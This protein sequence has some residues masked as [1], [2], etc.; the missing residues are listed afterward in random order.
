MQKKPDTLRIP[1][2]MIYN[3]ETGATNFKYRDVSKGD[4]EETIHRLF[5]PYFSKGSANA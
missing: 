4:F 2:S 1:I 3:P 5:G